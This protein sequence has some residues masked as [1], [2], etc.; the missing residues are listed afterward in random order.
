VSAQLPLQDG[1]VRKVGLLYQPHTPPDECPSDSGYRI[2]VDQL[3]TP[4]D[5]LTPQL[6]HLPKSDLDGRIEP[7]APQGA[8]QIL[9]TVSGCIT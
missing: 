2:Y 3:I 1:R 7:E 6:E 8:A 5:I 4:S 9:A